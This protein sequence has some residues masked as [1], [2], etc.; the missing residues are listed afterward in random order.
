MSPVDVSGDLN[1]SSACMCTLSQ[2]ARPKS[3]QLLDVCTEKLEVVTC[4]HGIIM[5]DIF[6]NEQTFHIYGPNDQRSAKCF[7]F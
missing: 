5:C 2:R 4:F 3:A 1:A 6:A 7:N